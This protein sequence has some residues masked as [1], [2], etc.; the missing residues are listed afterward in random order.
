[1]NIGRWVLVVTRLC[2]SSVTM[3]VPTYLDVVAVCIYVYMPDLSNETL[4]FLSLK[5]ISGLQLSAAPV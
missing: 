2:Y 1:M 3:T 5:H 4:G